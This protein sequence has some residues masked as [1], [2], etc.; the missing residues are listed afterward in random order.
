MIDYYVDVEQIRYNDIFNKN[1]CTNI[2]DEIFKD[3]LINDRI[4]MLRQIKQIPDN[5]YTLEEAQKEIKPSTIYIGL[6]KR[7]NNFK[8]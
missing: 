8:E 7:L 2:L 4:N 5:I 3:E 6:I 1:N